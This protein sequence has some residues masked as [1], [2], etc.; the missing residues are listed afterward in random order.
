MV[1]L[2]VAMIRAN[3]CCFRTHQSRRFVHEIDLF[4]DNNNLADAYVLVQ[5][6]RG[7]LVGEDSFLHLKCKSLTCILVL[8][9]FIIHSIPEYYKGILCNNDSVPILSN[10]ILM[11][12]YN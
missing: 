1:L 2:F 11:I 7:D 8:L 4:C 12:I 5:I 9:I 10:D 6:G 3:D